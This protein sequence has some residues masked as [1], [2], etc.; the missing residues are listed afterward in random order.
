MSRLTAI[1]AT[2]VT[3][4]ALL[5]SAARGQPAQPDASPIKVACMGDSIT[6]GYCSSA[7]N[8]TYPAVL[9]SILGPGYNVQNFGNSG[10]TMLKEGLCGPPA[11][12]CCSYW[13][14]PQFNESFAFQP[15]VVVLMLG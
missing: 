6:Y 8:Y 2:A 15:D 4:V 13:D 11:T 9:Q 5:A 3:T 10:R 1:A 12:C 7:P 14:V